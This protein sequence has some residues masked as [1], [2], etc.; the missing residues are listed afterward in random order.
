MLLL[1]GLGDPSNGHGGVS[2]LKMPLKLNDCLSSAKDARTSLNPV[3]RNPKSVTGTDADLRRLTKEK[4]RDK[5][6]ALINMSRKAAEL[7]QGVCIDK[8]SRWKM[9]SL[10]KD[11]LAEDNP[12]GVDESMDNSHERDSIRAQ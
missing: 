11:L 12:K 1:E 9:I 6:T 4:I 8:L 2:F 10:Y 7:M 3:M 5:L